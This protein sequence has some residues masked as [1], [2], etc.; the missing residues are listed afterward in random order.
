M[1]GPQRKIHNAWL[2]TWKIDILQKTGQ[3]AS[4]SLTALQ[5]TQQKSN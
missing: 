5:D 2:V 3:T 4:F 1:D